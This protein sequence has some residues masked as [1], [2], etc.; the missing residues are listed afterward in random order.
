MGLDA[1]RVELIVLSTCSDM[2][3]WS[4]FGFFAFACGFCIVGGLATI[5]W[6]VFLVSAF[7]R[8]FWESIM[9]RFI[10]DAFLCFLS[11]GYFLIGAHVVA[12]VLGVGGVCSV[13]AVIPIGL[14]KDATGLYWHS[15]FWLMWFL[16]GSVIF[17]RPMWGEVRS[18]VWAWCQD[19][20]RN[21]MYW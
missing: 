17:A 3:L 5:V 1:L 21:V 11:L 15:T 16:N 10:F 13:W 4:L 18:T 7:G 14:H 8:F 20:W 9:C 2:R 19:H 6:G 12:V